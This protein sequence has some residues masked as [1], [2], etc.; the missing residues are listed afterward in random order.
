MVDSAPKD[1]GLL[2]MDGNL[3]RASRGLC[4]AGWRRRVPLG[5]P[6]LY[7]PAIEPSS[8][9]PSLRSVSATGSKKGSNVFHRHRLRG[10][11]CD[12]LE[13]ELDLQR[14]ENCQWCACPEQGLVGAAA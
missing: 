14:M 12:A 9:R 3:N 4:L 13:Q 6:M 8:V 11:W 7:Q 10:G 2:F 1:A 5:V